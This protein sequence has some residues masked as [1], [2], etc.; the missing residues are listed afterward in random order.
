MRC[1]STPVVQWVGELAQQPSERQAHIALH[2]FER[3]VPSKWEESSVMLNENACQ[4]IHS[5]EAEVA[6]WLNH[7]KARHTVVEC[8]GLTRRK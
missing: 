8:A 6:K 3:Y 1:R 7:T 2:R 5:A 4:Q